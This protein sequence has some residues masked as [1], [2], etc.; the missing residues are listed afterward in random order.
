MHHIEMVTSEHLYNVKSQAEL[1]HKNKELLHAWSREDS[2]QVHHWN[3]LNTTLFSDST[4][5]K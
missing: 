2:I 3:H 5:Y 4:L 1:D